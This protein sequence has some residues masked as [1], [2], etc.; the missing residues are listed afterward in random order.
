[1]KKIAALLIL[2]PLCLCL[3]CLAQETPAYRPGDTLK[4]GSWGGEPIEWRVLEAADGGTYVLMSEKGLDARP[5]HTEAA[6]VTWESCSLRA[7]L[8]GAFYETAF[9]AAEKEKIVLTVTEN[10]DSELYGTPGGGDT[11]DR[12]T[13]LSLDELD[14]Y[15]GT[16]SRE[17]AGAEALICL[18]AQTAVDDGA[19]PAADIL[20]RQWQPNYAYT[21]KTGACRWWLRSPG[22]GSRRAA[23]VSAAGEILCHGVGV[24]SAE[25]C[26]R[27]VIRVTL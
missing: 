3:P 13:L 21:L 5:Y 17:G 27:P 15:F 1:M 11:E 8:N 23:C 24:D 19:A 12:V 9:T 7:W 4:L 25:E 10:P 6:A 26:V 16:E 2:L 20:V 22:G 14:R 18:P